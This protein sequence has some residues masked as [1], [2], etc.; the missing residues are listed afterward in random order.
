MGSSENSATEATARRIPTAGSSQQGMDPSTCNARLFAPWKGSVTSRTQWMTR[1]EASITRRAHSSAA[2]LGLT[3][4][5]AHAQQ[6]GRACNFASI[7]ELG[8]CC[9]DAACCS[10]ALVRDGAAVATIYVCRCRVWGVG[11]CRSEAQHLSFLPSRRPLSR[12]PTAKSVSSV[13]R[14]CRGALTI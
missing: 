2:M 1:A 11:G 8:C 14:W 9:S 10:A 6:F 4:M 7:W 5:Y 12:T 13:G 3:L